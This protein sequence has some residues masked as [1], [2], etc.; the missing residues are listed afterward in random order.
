[1]H[2]WTALTA[3]LALLL[4]VLGLQLVC[5]CGGCA[6]SRAWSRPAPEHTCCDHPD[7]PHPGEGPTLTDEPCGC[8][9]HA[10][11]TFQAHLPDPRDLS[12]PPFSAARPFVAVCSV[13]GC[14]LASWL[15]YPTGPPRSSGTPLYLRHA[16][17]L[18]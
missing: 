4:Q 2:R 18:I 17:L 16:S 8:R 12:A 6:L 10:L 11:A 13:V 3:T 9:D 1:M 7:P 5:L 14:N 15:P